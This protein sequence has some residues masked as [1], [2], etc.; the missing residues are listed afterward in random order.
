MID[1]NVLVQF[2]MEELVKKDRHLEKIDFPF[3]LVQLIQGNLHIEVASTIGE[4]MAT[5]KDIQQYDK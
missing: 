4:M 2:Y 3:M 1:D 5:H